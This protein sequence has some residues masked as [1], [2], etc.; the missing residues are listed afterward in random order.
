FCYGNLKDASF[1]DVWR[2]GKREQIFSDLV[3]HNCP[4][5]CRMDPLNRIYEKIVK[6][7]MSAPAELP[8]PRCEDHI[9]FL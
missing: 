1:R 3:V 7:E 8:E 4:A 2:S 9:N 6:G 5:A